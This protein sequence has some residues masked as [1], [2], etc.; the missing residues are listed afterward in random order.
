MDSQSTD[1]EAVLTHGKPSR[2]GPAFEMQNLLWRKFYNGS[3]RR[4]RFS[5][6]LLLTNLTG[7]SSPDLSGTHP[8]LSS[9]PSGHYLAMGG[10]PEQAAAVSQKATDVASIAAEEAREI[11]TAVKKLFSCY[12]GMVKTDDGTV[13][14]SGSQQQLNRISSCAKKTENPELQMHSLQL[15]V[16]DSKVVQVD[17]I[18]DKHI[19]S[20]TRKRNAQTALRIVSSIRQES[21]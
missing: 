1:F 13:L 16:H 2:T 19:Q 21:I 4:F 6:D 9:P 3:R 18:N 15:D 14:K 7:L 12:N 20:Q 11:A 17:K 5:I 10:R 8:L